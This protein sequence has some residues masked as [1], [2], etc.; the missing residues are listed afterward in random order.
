M[1]YG[2]SKMFRSPKTQGD[3]RNNVGPYVR[4]KRRPKNLPEAWDDIYRCYQRSWK[5]FRK[6]RWK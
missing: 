6:T 5:E 1:G 3:R 2:Y 4:P